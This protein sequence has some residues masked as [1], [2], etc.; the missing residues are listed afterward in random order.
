MKYEETGNFTDN[1]IMLCRE[2]AKM[3]KKLRK[4]GCDIICKGTDLNVY[5]TEDMD[6]AAPLIS[7][8]LDYS[9][10]VK[11]LVAGRINDCGSD[12]SEY[13]KCGYITD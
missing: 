11:S 2:I 7:S 9:H 8:F 4:S 1:Q 13:F 6:N 10:P 12:D 3:I 5:K